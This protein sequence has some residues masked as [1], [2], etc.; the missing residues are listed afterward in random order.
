MVFEKAVALKTPK[1]SMCHGITTMLN[2]IVALADYQLQAII[3]A[4][5]FEIVINSTKT[6]C[7][8]ITEYLQKISENYTTDE[9]MNIRCDILK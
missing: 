6:I 9:Q 3:E 1:M 7:N 8:L 4:N 5:D 2:E